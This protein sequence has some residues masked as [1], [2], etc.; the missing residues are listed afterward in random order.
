[1]AEHARGSAARTLGRYCYK[2]GVSTR[3][4]LQSLG[5]HATLQDF[6]AT[7]KEFRVSAGKVFAG[8]RNLELYSI[9]VRY[10]L[11]VRCYNVNNGSGSK[12]F[13]CCT[14]PDIS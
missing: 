9:T 11:R 1:M 13:S 14:A 4:A 5:V 10:L 3:Q 7:R 8:S 6:L 12:D 2:H